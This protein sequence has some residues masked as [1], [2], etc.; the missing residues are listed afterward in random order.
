MQ[1]IEVRVVQ[2]RE[3]TPDIAEFTLEPVGDGPLPPFTP[4]AHITVETP[5]GAMR[6]YSLMGDGR[7]PSAY[8]IAVK[9]EPESRGGSS[10]MHADAHEGT[11]LTIEP[12]EN[13]FELVDAPE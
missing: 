5:S 6:R 8:R 13:D 7:A 11:T 12:P 2:R 9:R 4:G 3:L 1:P 10:S